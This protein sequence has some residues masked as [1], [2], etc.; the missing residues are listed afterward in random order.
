MESSRPQNEGVLFI[1]RE[2]EKRTGKRVGMCVRVCV[3]DGEKAETTNSLSPAPCCPPH[4]CVQGPA[5]V[6]GA[7]SLLLMVELGLASRQLEF[8]KTE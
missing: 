8:S 3:C 7:M 1:L 2:G 5:F 4:V 6:C